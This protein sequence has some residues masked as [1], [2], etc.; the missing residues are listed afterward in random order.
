MWSVPT[1]LRA[2]YLCSSEYARLC[3]TLCTYLPLKVLL[4]AF[5]GRAL[6]WLPAG[7]LG[8][9]VSGVL[10]CHTPTNSQGHSEVAARVR[11]CTGRAAHRIQYLW[12]AAC[13]PP[14]QEPRRRHSGQSRINKL[15]NVAGTATHPSL[16]CFIARR[17]TKWTNLQSGAESPAVIA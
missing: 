7:L 12:E 6:G 4:R 3:V 17:R 14:W 10:S 2:V 9:S 5:H 13:P 15:P 8:N 11:G 1:G 16:C